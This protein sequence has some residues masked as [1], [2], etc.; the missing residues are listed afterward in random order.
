MLLKKL[1]PIIKNHMA[2][3]NNIMEPLEFDD[4]AAEQVIAEAF[5]MEFERLFDQFGEQLNVSDA[6]YEKLKQSFNAAL[7][8]EKVK[9]NIFAEAEELWKVLKNTDLGD[10]LAALDVDEDEKM[11]IVT[12]YIDKQVG[13]LYALFSEVNLPKLPEFTKY[14]YSIAQ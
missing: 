4:D 11:E 8:S 10:Q 1:N 5:V 6:Q 12:S 7:K 3:L 9:T 13:D 2:H 14:L